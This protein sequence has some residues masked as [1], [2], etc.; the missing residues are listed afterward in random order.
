VTVVVV[1][2]A[3]LSG[4]GSSNTSGRSP[5]SS[6]VTTAPASAQRYPV[7]T[8]VPILPGPVAPVISKI[9]TTNPVMFFTIDDGLVRDPAAVSYIRANHIPVTLFILPVPIQQDPS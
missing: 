7:A 8:P 2:V 9:T 3:V 5:T 1:G 6:T 4:G